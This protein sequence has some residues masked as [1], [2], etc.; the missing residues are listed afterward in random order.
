MRKT[1]LCLV[2][3]FLVI[4]LDVLLF[5]YFSQSPIFYLYSLSATVVFSFIAAL[6]AFFAFRLHGIES[7]QGKAFFCMFLGSIF[8]FVAESVWLVLELLYNEAVPIVSLAD[9]FYYAGYLLFLLGFYYIWKAS[10]S[11]NTFMLGCVVFLAAMLL[12]FITSFGYLYENMSSPDV[13]TLE[14]LTTTGYAFLDFVIISSGI[15]VIMIMKR[16]NI[17]LSWTI[18]ISGFMFSAFGDVLYA[19]FPT[20]YEAGNYLDLLWHIS[21]ILTAAGYI[22]YYFTVNEMVSLPLKR[23]GEKH[24]SKK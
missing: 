5:A 23:Y 9:P 10:R 4:L 18:I 16:N 11:S 7:I 15:C 12:M 6:T 24:G 2:A 19:Q 8:W 3:I 13:N 1:E 17:S 14:K 22:V 20:F 21:Y